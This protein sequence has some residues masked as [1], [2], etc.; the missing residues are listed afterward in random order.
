ME[1]WMGGKDWTRRPQRM[2]MAD[3]FQTSRELL[4]V[5]AIPTWNVGKTSKHMR[6]LQPFSRWNLGT[7]L[8][9]G[10]FLPRKLWSEKLGSGQDH[11]PTQDELACKGKPIGSG[12][13]KH[14]ELSSSREEPTND[15][16]KSRERRWRQKIRKAP[17]LCFL[18]SLTVVGSLPWIPPLPPSLFEKQTSKFQDWIDF[19]QWSMNEASSI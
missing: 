5:P 17:H 19:I 11:L 6:E 2:E 9:T 15:P 3:W 7:E 10:V 1:R 16:Q 14:R 12:A 18:L 13:W 4:L 8:K